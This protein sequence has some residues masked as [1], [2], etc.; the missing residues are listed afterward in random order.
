MKTQHD[1]A[2]RKLLQNMKSKRKF[3]IVKK[4]D[5]LGKLT[6]LRICIFMF[7]EE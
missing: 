5:E 7:D 4:I 6:N 3:H 2:Q 1:K